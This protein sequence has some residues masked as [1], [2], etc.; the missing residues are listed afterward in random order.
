MSG[1]FYAAPSSSGCVATTFRL[2]AGGAA[3]KRRRRGAP[4]QHH[5]AA[6]LRT[7]IPDRGHRTSVCM[8][9]S[10]PARLG[11]RMHTG[12]VSHHGAEQGSTP[13]GGSTIPL[14]QRR[15]G[16]AWWDGPGPALPRG[17]SQDDLKV[18]S[19]V[20]RAVD[21]GRAEVVRAP[22]TTLSAHEAWRGK[23]RR[24]SFVTPR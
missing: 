22:P 19:T 16:V 9:R 11:G 6:S 7:E 18:D 24:C 20:D 8:T 14:H 13:V 12:P 23:G 17:P 21:C 3:P 10:S 2:S 5:F 15:R 1:Q 4:R